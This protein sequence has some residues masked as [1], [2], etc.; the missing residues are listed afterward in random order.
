MNNE[1]NYES[2]LRIQQS[3]HNSNHKIKLSQTKI[4]YNKSH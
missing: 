1:F 2:Y 4:I 3:I